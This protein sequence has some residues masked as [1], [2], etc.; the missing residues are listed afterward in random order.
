MALLPDTSASVLRRR[1]TDSSEVI[2]QGREIGFLTAS[3]EPELHPLIREFLLAK[4]AATPDRDERVRGAIAES[5]AASAWT[6]AF[7]LI[8]RFD[9]RDMLER[10]LE[11]AYRPLL[12]SGR[13]STLSEVASAMADERFPPPIVDLIDADVAHRSG[14]FAVSDELA[15]RAKDRWSRGAPLAGRAAVLQGQNGWALSDLEHAERACREALAI[16]NHDADIGD[17]LYGLALVTL[18]SEDTRAAEMTAR[19]RERSRNTLLDFLRYESVALLEQRLTRGFPEP[20]ELDHVLAI[21]QRVGDIRLQTM[22]VLI[23]SNAYAFRADFD[24]ALR[25]CDLAKKEAA[26]FGLDFAFPHIYAHLG[27]LQVGIRK[28]GD[29]EHSLLR[30][31]EAVE[32][33]PNNHHE[34]NARILRAQIALALSRYDDAVR[35]T[36]TRGIGRDVR[37]T[38]AEVC[39]LGAIGLAT[40][41]DAQR[42]LE[43]AEAADAISQAIEIRA[44]TTATRSIVAARAGKTEQ[45]RE[46]L[47]LARRYGMWNAL[48]VAMR[49]SP[50]LFEAIAAD[51]RAH[52][53]LAL[54][55]RKSRDWALARK[56]GIQLR[57]VDDPQAVLTPRELEVLDLLCQGLRNRE[58]SA[59]LVIADSTTKVHVRH[60]LEKLGVRSR[61]EAAA[62]YRHLLD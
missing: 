27:M 28:F 5:T 29:A 37:A 52:R 46:I 47:V 10:T 11:A 62:R 8:L 55:F 43:A 14:A 1:W 36:T 21:R 33:H 7:E 6:T 4:V 15:Q 50:E 40:R 49:A 12:G 58:I 56:A 25:L 2:D 20:L 38:R 26:E 13:L 39:A 17:A 9:V 18:H 53:D 30:L 45:S 59:A 57:P 32:R 34:L 16:G 24:E 41:G 48:L 54:L 60:V 51:D 35:A 31:E 23:A 22:F 42:A 3:E 19:L 61:A 44:L